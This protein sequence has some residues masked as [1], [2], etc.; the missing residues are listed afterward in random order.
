MTAPNRNPRFAALDDTHLQAALRNAVTAAHEAVRE[1][2][3][4][5]T[6]MKA[7]GMDHPLMR[8]RVYKFHVE[9]S[10]GELTAEAALMLN[11]KP[12]VIKAVKGLPAEVQNELAT[13][14]RIDVLTYDDAGN[15]IHSKRTALSLKPAEIAR[16]IGRE[17][18][19]SLTQ[20]RAI[21]AE[22][23][24]EPPAP[25][26]LPRVRIRADTETGELL[27]GA[28]RVRPEQLAEALAELGLMLAPHVRTRRRA[29]A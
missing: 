24:P 6:E 26:T 8:H 5:L 13:G 2:C 20:Q 3:D 17:G 15:V 10:T 27:I 1:V 12:E 14:K 7:R 18:I 9:V 19:R 16:A 23:A 29:T 11:V 4:I 25:V 21:V 22:Q 28:H